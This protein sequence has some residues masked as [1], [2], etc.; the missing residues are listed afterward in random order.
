MDPRREARRTVKL[1]LP[2]HWAFSPIKEHLRGCQGEGWAILLERRGGR[3][4]LGGWGVGV[5]TLEEGICLEG[6]G[7]GGGF[8]SKW[9]GLLYPGD[10]FV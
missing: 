8:R 2:R 7:G 9:V 10:V 5:A 1:L 4:W 3:R 6:T